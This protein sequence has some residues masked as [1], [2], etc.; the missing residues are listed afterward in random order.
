M[1]SNKVVNAECRSCG[2]YKVEEVWLFPRTLLVK[3]L[4]ILNCAN[5]NL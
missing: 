4:T 3:K 1:T 5:K 2:I